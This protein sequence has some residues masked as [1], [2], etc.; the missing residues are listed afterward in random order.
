MLFEIFPFLLPSSLIIS[1]LPFSRLKIYFFFSNLPSSLILLRKRRRSNLIPTFHHP[2][3]PFF[4][5]E[6]G[7]E[8]KEKD[9]DFPLFVFFF[10]SFGEECFEFKERKEKWK[11][12]FFPRKRIT[13]FPKK[14]FELRDGW[15]A[16]HPFCS[17]T[18]MAPP[19]WW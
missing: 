15:Q 16:F 2:P 3:L 1:S 11:R 12:S 10:L 7:K 6:R 18:L 9:W 8:E 14:S 4:S 19:L 17:L 13:L 5:Q